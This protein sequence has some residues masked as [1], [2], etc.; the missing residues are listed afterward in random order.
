MRPFYVKCEELSKLDMREV[1]NHCE[2]LPGEGDRYFGQYDYFGLTAKGEA[3]WTDT[4]SKY[5]EEAVYIHSLQEFRQEI[6]GEQVQEEQA[7]QKTSTGFIKTMQTYLELFEKMPTEDDKKYVA[8]RMRDLCEGE[9]GNMDWVK[10]DLTGMEAEGVLL[11]DNVMTEEGVNVS[12][13]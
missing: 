12:G 6:L 1:L 11:S 8:Q 7:G 13:D 2:H 4:A 10:L 5:S 9:S 3:Y